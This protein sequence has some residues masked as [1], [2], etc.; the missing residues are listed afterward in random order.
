MED[1]SPMRQ[2]Y[3]IHR[4][5]DLPFGLQIQSLITHPVRP[6]WFI[7]ASKL[8][9]VELNTYGDCY[10][11]AGPASPQ[12]QML[13][14]CNSVFDSITHIYRPDFTD[15]IVFVLDSIGIH[16]FSMSNCSVQHDLSYDVP[17]GTYMNKD[18]RSSNSILVYSNVSTSTSKLYSRYTFPSAH[19]W[20]KFTMPKFEDKHRVFFANH[21]CSLDIQVVDSSEMDDLKNYVWVGNEL[22]KLESDGRI[23]LYRT[24]NNSVLK[25]RHS[26]LSLFTD[27]VESV[28]ALDNDEFGI[29]AKANGGSRYIATLSH[30]SNSPTTYTTHITP[31]AVTNMIKSHAR[32]SIPA[33]YGC[34]ISN[35]TAISS[36]PNVSL[37]SCLY[38]C[39]HEMYCLGVV[40]TPYDCTLLAQIVT[41]FAIQFG[42]CYELDYL[43]HGTGN[44]THIVPGM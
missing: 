25:I 35:S 30:V 21:N 6:G 22:I 34:E 4:T 10:I 5:V 37:T 33:G 24:Y 28:H 3:I 7:A 38:M 39:A 26:D 13:H 15:D 9:L 44:G 19:T 23:T 2:K 41:A 27:L 40:L 14:W 11:L 8:N 12:C 43:G 16:E 32:Y 31:L 29:V 17:K 1:T 36:V 42:E 20:R 18:C